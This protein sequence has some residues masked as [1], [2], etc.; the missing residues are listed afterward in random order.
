MTR[1]SPLLA[2][3]KAL[4]GTRNGNGGGGEEEMIIQ[5]R[6]DNSW[7]LPGELQVRKDGGFGLAY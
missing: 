4:F 6:N 7:Q 3:V 2:F 1:K 5:K